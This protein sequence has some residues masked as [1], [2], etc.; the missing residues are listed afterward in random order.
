MDSALINIAPR[1]I[2]NATVQT[3]NARDLHAFLGV[4][5]DFSS[6]LKERVEQYGFIE[7]QDF[8]I[9]PRNGGQMERGRQFIEYALTLDTAKELSMVERT[10]KGK[11]ARQYFLE[12]ERRAKAPD[13]GKAL[14]DPAALRGLLL[15]YTERVIELEAQN[16]LMAPKAAFH[17]AVTEAVNTQTISEAAK[18]LGMGP[19][20]LFKVLRDEGLLMRNNLPFQQQ[21]DA[22]RFKVLAKSY[23][24]SNGEN[25]NYTQT[26]VTGKGLAFLQK[27]LAVAEV[28]HG[29]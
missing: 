5:R 14:A 8:T 29:R 16:S 6:W 17:D 19:A 12:C 27:R 7:N 22:G 18:V 15:T 20:I 4:G 28:S 13:L 2:G 24:D 26:V 3:V 25:R 10:E 23:K 9:Y 11:Q 21:L 1:P